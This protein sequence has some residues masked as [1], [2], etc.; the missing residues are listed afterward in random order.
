MEFLEVIKSRR[1]IRSFKPDPIE[2][3]KLHE[4]LEAGRS[5]PSAQNKQCWRF[6][7]INDKELIKKVAFHSI[8][9]SVN[10]FLKD[11]PLIIIAC[12]DPKRSVNLNKQ[13][14]YLVDTAIAFHQMML[15]AWSYGIGSCWLAAFDEKSIRKLLE[16]PED[17][18]IV[19]ISPF[20]YP[21]EK[22]NL[23]SKAVSAFSSSKKRL[24]FN[25]LVYYNI[26]NRNVNYYQTEEEGV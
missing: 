3:E 2:E 6:I 1:S 22:A 23:Y 18:R 15:T 12:A 9:G 5:A 19:G 7:V 16:I 26:W 8:I 17:I 4:I 25:Q 14:Y 11:A 21:A 13:E 24:A 10:F 20:G